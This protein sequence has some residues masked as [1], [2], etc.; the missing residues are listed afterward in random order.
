MEDGATAVQS[1]AT[2][3]LND[4][5]HSADQE[6]SVQNGHE[7]TSEEGSDDHEM[8]GPEDSEGS[9]EQDFDGENFEDDDWEEFDDNQSE[10]SAGPPEANTG[11]RRRPTLG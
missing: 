9:D 4:A 10:E 1:V 5:Q 6:T 11:R 7:P 3:G 8:I 2:T